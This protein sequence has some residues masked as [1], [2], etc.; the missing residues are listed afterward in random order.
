MR[1]V[2]A[3]GGVAGLAAALAI[4]R[5]GHEA[6]APERDPVD[7]GGS[8]EGAFG[9]A[10]RGI[11][12]YLEPHAFLPR[13]RQLLSGWA[14][15]VLDALLDVGADPQDVALKLSG[16]RQPV[17]RTWWS[18]SAPRRSARRRGLGFPGVARDADADANAAATR[19]A[20]VTGAGA[21]ARVLVLPPRCACSRGSMFLGCPIRWRVL[22]GTMTMPWTP[23]MSRRWA[24]RSPR[25]SRRT[26]SCTRRAAC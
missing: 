16:P 6:V 10:R 5:V 24:A 25:R 19:D 13:G 22:L 11:P 17:T 12:H 8:P 23:T 9:V 20:D 15:D 4:A 21:G 14:P 1:F 3:G 2:V 26:R 7:P 18:G